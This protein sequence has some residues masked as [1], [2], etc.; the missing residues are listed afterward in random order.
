[1]VQGLGTVMREWIDA[2]T[3]MPLTAAT[4]TE[5]QQAAAAAR[6]RQKQS[7]KQAVQPDTVAATDA[8]MPDAGSASAVQPGTEA[9]VAG[10]ASGAAAVSAA[11]QPAQ[12]AA[13]A[14]AGGTTDGVVPVAGAAAVVQQVAEVVGQALPDAASAAGTGAV[15]QTAYAAGAQAAGDAL[16][17]QNVVSQAA[18]SE[19][20]FE[21]W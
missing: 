12:T 3:Y 9:N 2:G 5:E 21:E 7:A 10:A 18:V 15:Q 8:A 14:D 13:Q 1:M 19:E 17:S 6:F 4:C 20:P 16:T 11:Q